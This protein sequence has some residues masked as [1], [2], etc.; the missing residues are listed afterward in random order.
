MKHT[1]NVEDFIEWAS[2]NQEEYYDFFDDHLSEEIRQDADVYLR[3]ANKYV[4]EFEDQF[5]EIILPIIDELEENDYFGTEG[6]NK[7]FA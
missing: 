5:E 6:F 1:I 3:W 4:E 2:A 7:R